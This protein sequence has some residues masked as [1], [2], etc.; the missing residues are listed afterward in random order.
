MP[1]LLPPTGQITLHANADGYLI[2]IELA[3]LPFQVQRVFSV[4]AKSKHASRGKHLTQCR[5]LIILT[6]GSV[7]VHTLTANAVQQSFH[8]STPGEYVYIAAQNYIEYAMHHEHTAILVFAD[9]P[10]R[11]QPAPPYPQP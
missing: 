6:A 11:P 9:Q 5:E 10:Y 4:T 2:P 7:T 3:D 8:L 1:K